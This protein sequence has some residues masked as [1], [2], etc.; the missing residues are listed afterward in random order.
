MRPVP[1]EKELRANGK[2]IHMSNRLGISEATL[3]D[4]E[5]TIYGHATSTCM[6][7]RK[8]DSSCPIPFKS[9]ENKIGEIAVSK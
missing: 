5:G 4:S 2:V 1:R 7:L 9:S 6:I 3:M 8:K